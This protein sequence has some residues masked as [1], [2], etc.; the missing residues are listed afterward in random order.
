MLDPLLIYV[1]LSGTSN[2]GQ[3]STF[4][5]NILLPSSGLQLGMVIFHWLY[6]Q[7]SVIVLSLLCALTEGHTV[8]FSRSLI[9][10][11]VKIQLC[12][13]SDGIWETELIYGYRIS[14]Q[15]NVTRNYL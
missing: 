4:P 7:S 11:L 14:E 1:S 13:R 12:D 9:L 5:L 3:P 2:L 8:V 15:F 10:R 6:V